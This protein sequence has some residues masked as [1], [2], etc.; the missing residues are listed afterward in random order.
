MV[1]F[2]FLHVALQLKK[3]YLSFIPLIKDLSA[4]G[5]LQQQFNTVHLCR[6]TG[7]PGV[8]FGSC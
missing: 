5:G 7:T 4:T 3:H 8:T 6:K 1:L 2:G